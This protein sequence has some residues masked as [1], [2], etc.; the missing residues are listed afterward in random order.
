MESSQE[1][2]INLSCDGLIQAVKEEFLKIVE[3]RTNPTIS[4]SDALMSAFAMFS[5]KNASLLEFETEKTKNQNLKNIY[6]IN[7]IPSDTQMREIIDGIETKK[8]RK[9]FKLLF[10]F[11][12]RGKVL[13]S[14]RVLNDYYILS[15]DGTGFF[16]SK[17]IHCECCLKKNKSDGT[18][19][20]H[21]I[22]SACIVHPDKKEVFP[23]MPEPITNQDGNTKNDCELNASKRFVEDFR[24]EHPHLKVIFVE[25]SLF[26]NAPHIELLKSKN[27]SFIIGAQETNH[28]YL[29]KQLDELVKSGDTKQIH[30]EKD[31]AYHYFSFANGLSLNE[32]SDTKVNI[33]EYKQIDKEEEMNPFSWVT[34]IEITEKNAYELMKIARARWK[35]ENETFNTLKNQGY[36]LEHNFGH[37]KKNLSNNFAILMMLVFLVDQIQQASCQLFRKA[38][39]TFHAKKYFWQQVRSLFN[40]F[41]FNSMEELLRAIAFGFKAQIVL[42]DKNSS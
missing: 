9:A 22:Y 10:S 16:S 13:E 29:Y 5:L 8:L 32:S 42:L 37:G 23:I 27:I 35:I 7:Q 21:M 33:L 28:K 36:H 30:I 40:T 11:L 4:L 1:I 41:E 24:R 17:T 18:H 2:R 3:H 6:K 39:G 25:D 14:Y 20:H 31:G 26:S 38:L 15:G 34:D 19:Y 12:Q